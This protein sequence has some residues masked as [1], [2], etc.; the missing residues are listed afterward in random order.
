MNTNINSEDKKLSNEIIKRDDAVYKE[1]EN[2]EDYELTNNVAYE[3]MIRNNEFIKDRLKLLLTNQVFHLKYGDDYTSMMVELAKISGLNDILE[4]T[5]NLTSF[6]PS[7]FNKLC[8]DMIEKW[9]IYLDEIINGHKSEIYL[10]SHNF[11]KVNNEY[12][13]TEH[14]TDLKED[15]TSHYDFISSRPSIEIKNISKVVE[16]KLNLSLPKDELIAI[17]SKIKDEADVGNIKT[18]MELL[19]T[20]LKKADNLICDTKGK[21]FD[22]REILSKQQKLADMFYIYDCLKVGMSQRKIQN[23]VYNYYADKGIETKT[24][25]QKTLKRYKEIAIDYI[26]NMRYKELV[27]GVKLEDL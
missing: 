20:E 17:I 4:D 24:L 6:N 23:E 10:T 11:F 22:A 26:D 3:M 8:E 18:P 27:T 5:N 12:K 13:L 9:G 14:I 1:I 21:C 15:I 25:D 2:F 16:L 19:G 7:S